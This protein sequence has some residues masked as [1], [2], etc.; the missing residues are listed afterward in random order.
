LAW[1]SNTWIT[2]ISTPCPS[3]SAAGDKGRVAAIL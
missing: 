1:P 3:S 2:R